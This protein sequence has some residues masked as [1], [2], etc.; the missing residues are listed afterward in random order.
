M[1]LFVFVSALA[2]MFAAGGCKQGLGQR[3]QIDSDC[4]SGFVC[5][6]A[7]NTCEDPNIGKPVDGALPVDAPDDAAVDAPT[8]AAAD[9]MI[10]AT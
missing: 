5:V 1:R 6:S 7:T 4:K 10:D 2:V 8:D 3:C 9:A